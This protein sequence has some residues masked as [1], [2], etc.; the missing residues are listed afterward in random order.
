M[1][2]ALLQFNKPNLISIVRT[3]IPDINSASQDDNMNDKEVKKFQQH[4]YLI[5]NLCK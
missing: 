2:E 4:L 1:R 3:A 5:S